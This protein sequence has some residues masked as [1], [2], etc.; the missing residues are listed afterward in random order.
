MRQSRFCLHVEGDTPS[1]SR[2]FA[3]IASAC[4]PVAVADQLELPWEAE[5]DYSRFTVFVSMEDA[6]VPGRLASILRGVDER[7]WLQLWLN[8]RAVQH[9]FE[10]QVRRRGG[11]GWVDAF[12]APL[13]STSEMQVR[14]RVFGRQVGDEPERKEGRVYYVI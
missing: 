12:Q 5:L 2:F 6:L 14:R 11:L 1:S 3:A 13:V 4:V 7:Q 8:V 10:M 9:H